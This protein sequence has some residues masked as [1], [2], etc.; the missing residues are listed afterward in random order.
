[1]VAVGL[2]PR[3]LRRIFERCGLEANRVL[4]TR[5]GP[6]VMDRALSR[7]RSRRLTEGELV[8]LREA[9]GLAA[10]RRPRGRPRGDPP[11]RGPKLRERAPAGSRKRGH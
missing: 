5:F 4:R 11:S 10:P 2:R 3:D 7:G 6:I 9:V 8:A 1:V